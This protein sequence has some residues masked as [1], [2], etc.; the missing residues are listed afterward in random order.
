MSSS[1]EAEIFEN[2]VRFN[3]I[4]RDHTSTVSIVVMVRGGVFREEAETLGLGSLFARTWLKTGQILELSE[5]YGGHVGANIGADYFQYSLSVPSSVLDN[6]LPEFENFVVDPKFT[7]SIFDVE[8]ELLLKELAAENDDPNSI[9]YQKYLE[10]T[11]FEHPYALKTEGTEST[12]LSLKLSNVEEYYKNNLPGVETVVV[13][14]GNFSDK[15]KNAVKEIYRKLAKGRPVSINCSGAVIKENSIATAKDTRIQQAKLFMAYTAPSA[16]DSR[17][18]ATKVLENLLGGGMSSPYFNELRK[19]KGYAYS[20]GA[21]YSASLCES[22]FT[23]YIDLQPENV[24]DA[25]STMKEI[26]LNV[27]DISEKDIERAKNHTVGQILA[28]VETNYM[29]AM[30]SAFFETL[31]LG[32]NYMDKYVN[33]LRQVSKDDVVEA[34]EIFR[35]PYTIFVFEPTGEK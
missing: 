9:A 15:Q 26:N 10:A 35:E 14:S 22:R 3:S 23:G 18:V 7:K 6:V 28:R 8:K 4:K 29:Q 31:G 34:A 30:Y 33:S 5:Y 21:M 19:N 16:T 32:F 20:V 17:Y 12:V 13:I 25:I 11:Y 24:E 2:G 1:V 27:A